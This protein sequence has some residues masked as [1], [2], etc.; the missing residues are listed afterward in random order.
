MRARSC[1]ILL[2]LA[3]FLAVTLTGCG[4]KGPRASGDVEFSAVMT[5]VEKGVP[6]EYAVSF[7]R[8]KQRIS[9]LK[10]ETG[11]AVIVRLDKGVVWALM[12]AMK[13]FLEMGVKPENKSPLVYDPDDILEWEKVGEE[14]VD[15]HPAVKEKL[16]IRNKGDQ[17][18]T[19]YRWFA[20]D[21]G[22][23]VKAEALDGSWSISYS[24]IKAGPQDPALFE[25]PTGYMKV[26]RKPVSH[27][28][29]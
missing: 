23:P 25:P 28:G 5:D 22:W 1:W 29:R 2:V 26:V 14:T 4:K 19:F 18:K 11:G 7:T 17:P 13:L 20:T 21:I 24:N 9:L 10:D 15:G 3:A 12:P 16:T 8:G 27:M 6:A